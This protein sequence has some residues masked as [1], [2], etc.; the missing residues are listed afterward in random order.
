MWICVQHWP[1][2]RSRRTFCYAQHALQRTDSCYYSLIHRL[3]DTVDEDRICT[4]GVNM[5]FGGLIYGASEMKKQA[6]AD[7]KPIAW[8]TAARC[9]DDRLEALIPEAAKH[10]SFVWL[11]DA[12][13]GDSTRAVALAKANPPECIRPAG[14]SRR[15]G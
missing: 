8:I 2:S 3:L 1:K 11:L 10:G 15:A 12:T 7:G 6:D 5:G 14:G 4:V 9:G 13:A